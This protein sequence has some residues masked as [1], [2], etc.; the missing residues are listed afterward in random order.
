MQG[1]VPAVPSLRL[2]FTFAYTFVAPPMQVPPRLSRRSATSIPPPRSA[3][4]H[5]CAHSACRDFVSSP[6]SVLKELSGNGIDRRAGARRRHGWRDEDPWTTPFR[7]KSSQA[8][9]VHDASVPL[10]SSPTG[11]SFRFVGLIG[12][13][14][15][16]RSAVADRLWLRRSL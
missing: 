2:I 13:Q 16:V 14:D 3:S 12:F 10:P 9:A 4:S 7:C 15:P 1:S 5:A 8:R 6:W 11:F